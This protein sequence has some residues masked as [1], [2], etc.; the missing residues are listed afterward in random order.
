MLIKYSSNAVQKN[1]DLVEC[2]NNFQKELLLEAKILDVEK[3]P[4][5]MNQY[6]IDFL[7]H[8]HPRWWK[9]AVKKRFDLLFEALKEREEVRKIY[10]DK[11]YDYQLDYAKKELERSP[12]LK[13][14]SSDV[15]DAMLKNT[16]HR[17]T[18]EKIIKL[19]DQKFWQGTGRKYES[20]MEFSFLGSGNKTITYDANP[21]IKELIETIEGEV[22]QKGG[23]DLSNPHEVKI[24]T[25]GDKDETKVKI[26]RKTNGFEFPEEETINE[27]QKKWLVGI[28]NGLLSAKKI[29]SFISSDEEGNVQKHNVTH[30]PSAEVFGNANMKINDTFSFDHEQKRMY[31][32]LRKLFNYFKNNYNK[33]KLAFDEAKS[34]QEKANAENAKLKILKGL[35]ENLRTQLPFASKYPNCD[36]YK[37]C[38]GFFH[39]LTMD[40]KNAFFKKAFDDEQNNLKKAE[41]GIPDSFFSNE[42]L[43][44]TL[45]RFLA[46][47][48]LVEWAKEGK[49][50][51][52]NNENVV[53][54]SEKQDLVFPELKIPTFEKEL[55][56]KQKKHASKGGG[57]E[58]KT[59]KVQMP[60]LLKGGFVKE[61]EED[62]IDHSTQHEALPRRGEMYNPRTGRVEPRFVN[63][64][65]F[66]KAG[67]QG[68]DHDR[69]GAYHPTQHIAGVEFLDI[70]DPEIKNRLEKLIREEELCTYKMSTKD[71]TTRITFNPAS[72]EEK[73]TVLCGVAKAI[74]YNLTGGETMDK[75]DLSEENEYALNNFPILYK[76]VIISLLNN[77]NSNKFYY[78][79]QR[80]QYISQLITDFKQKNIAGKQTRRKRT[81]KADSEIKPKEPIQTKNE[82]L[83]LINK[84]KYNFLMSCSEKQ[85]GVCTPCNPE[86][87][88]C[89]IKAAYPIE[90][91]VKKAEE[92]QDYEDKA[93]KNL[94]P[95]MIEKHA[96]EADRIEKMLIALAVAKDLKPDEKT[97]QGIDQK[98]ETTAKEIKDLF[99]NEK[100]KK[101][102]MV[103]TVKSIL[104]RMGF[105]L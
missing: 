90:A 4:L 7:H 91:I 40:S 62:D 26:R 37:D 15:Q 93:E 10:Y 9:Q 102:S 77:L 71:G 12:I 23:I 74:Y 35:V 94:N 47:K 101:M 6:D 105:P 44:D 65:S 8:F 88:A 5:K 100:S 22:G 2:I 25:S 66:E 31:K 99:S 57:Y 49:L 45:I 1:S 46:A 21:Y 27:I 43:F 34:S 98:I 84:L 11:L 69:I 96:D 95:N 13:F 38:E 75:R 55:K 19:A 78:L 24:E 39:D 86:E 73:N 81:L 59:E 103:D 52:A 18:L 92:Y 76:F 14:L 60:V 85:K 54:D 30:I 80:R 87:H 48:Q 51:N 97:L 33:A 58:E 17:Q 82:L 50:K 63:V 42:S 56:Y 67:H 61:H 28:A 104:K 29:N 79:N 70:R 20:N 68:T 41:L 64:D 83:N 53:F 72:H 16:A 89:E 36:S 3:M 32:S